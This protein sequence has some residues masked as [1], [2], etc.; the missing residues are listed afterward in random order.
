M[1]FFLFVFKREVYDWLRGKVATSKGASSK[2]ATDHGETVV[3]PS[4]SRLAELADELEMDP[5]PV[6]S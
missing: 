6:A 5:N 3:S 2:G 4:K 1:A